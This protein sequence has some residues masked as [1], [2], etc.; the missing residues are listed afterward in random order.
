MAIR[1]KAELYMIKMINDNEFV[2]IIKKIKRANCLESIKNVFL[3]IQQVLKSL[4]K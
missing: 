1:L 4:K 2:T 3:L